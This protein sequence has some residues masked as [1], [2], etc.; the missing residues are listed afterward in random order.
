[1]TSTSLM[2]AQ[3]QPR[4]RTIGPPASGEEDDVSERGEV[5]DT[6][7]D[8]TRA[9]AAEAGPRLRELA[10]AVG[11]PDFI[12]PWLDR[13]YD[14]DDAA[15][16]V[17]AAVGDL[18]GAHPALLERAHRRAILDGDDVG[19]YKPADFHERLEFWAM[20]EGWK[21]VPLAARRQL[22]DWDVDAYAAKIRD[23]VEDACAGHPG[24]SYEAR[25]TYVLLE[26]AEAILRA[27]EHVYLW[28]CDCRS[29]V[30]RCRK[31]MDVC[32]RF[33]NDR[34]VGW[35][36]SPE[37]AI[38]ILHAADKAGLMH[39]A[40][41]TGDPVASTS[42]CNCCTD[43]CYPHLASERLDVAEE[44]P[45]R[46]HVAAVDF[47]ACKNCGRCGLRCPFEAIVCRTDGKPEL[48]AAL[49]RGCGLC[50]TGCSTDAITLVP[51]PGAS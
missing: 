5:V 14:T 48:D 26:E 13:F 30:G 19:T 32:L 21:D 9:T 29:I 46:R 12:V 10:A 15:L 16:V 39:T 4:C 50:A 3:Q 31:S 22:A 23:N 25:Y 28:P 6:A 11:A 17:A 51:L 1:M 45:L 37:R 20:F 27:Q 38:Q 35:E 33:A 2:V 18:D 44:W 34:G 40:D 24:A 36:I 47:E 42:I 43:C 49:C 7:S 41:Y 8:A